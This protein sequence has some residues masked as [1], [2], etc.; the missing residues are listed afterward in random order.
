MLVISIIHM[1]GKEIE[2]LYSANV[3]IKLKISV[4][5]FWKLLIILIKLE[6]L[7]KLEKAGY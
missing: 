5:N 2:M 3:K 6:E 7:I 4:S 1:R